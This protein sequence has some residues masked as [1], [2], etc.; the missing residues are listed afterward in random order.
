MK[1]VSIIIPAYNKAALTVKTVESVLAQTYHNI[2]IIVI[3]DGSSDNTRILLEPYINRIKYIYRTNGGACSARNLG[4]KESRGD[5]IGLLDC[6]DTYHPDKVRLA[7]EYFQQHLGCAMIHTAANFINDQGKI[8][9]VYSSWQS[10]FVGKIAD[11]LILNNYI[12]NSTVI[13]KKECFQKVGDFDQTF[14]IPADWDMWLRIAEEF[15]VGYINQPLT[16]YLSAGSFTL[17]NLDLWEK[18]VLLML[19]KTFA[20]RKDLSR[21][22]KAKVKANM[23]FRLALS[24]LLAGN[25]VSAKEKFKVALYSDLFN[26]KL[27][28]VG[29]IFLVSPQLLLKIAKRKVFLQ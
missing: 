2:E 4:I 19:N 28:L 25:F 6:D 11:R 3:D 5:Y 1:L 18:E 21:G 24:Y 16:N 23:Y 27:I 12:C 29:L 22:L 14:F 8:L 7:M 10:R 9:S 20:R 13:A 17:R 15:Q 26:V